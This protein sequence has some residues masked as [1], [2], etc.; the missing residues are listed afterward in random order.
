MEVVKNRTKLLQY[1]SRGTCNVV[2]RVKQFL[3]R[4]RFTLQTDHKPLKYLFAPDEKIPKTAS[5]GI[6]RWA[7]ALMGFE[8]ELKYKPGE[9]IPH[10][11]ALSGLDFDDDKDN[12]RGCLAIDNM[13]TIRPGDPVRHQNSPGIDSTLPRCHQKI[14][15][16]TGNSAQKK[17]KVSNNRK[18]P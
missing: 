7:I 17:R 16:K 14:K 5:P 10:A 2:A 1:C 12:D 8:I 13:F 18:T 9:Q 4:R 11:D 15:T 3:L 6:R